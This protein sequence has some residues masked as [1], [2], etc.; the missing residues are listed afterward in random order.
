M[1]V[2]EQYA[3]LTMGWCIDC[4]RE[5]GVKMEGNGYYDEIHS[6]LPAH[7][8]EEYMKDGKI[9]VDELGGIECAKCHY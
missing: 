1:P 5:T 8:A 9:T 2:V 6:R 7:F 4:H 3:P